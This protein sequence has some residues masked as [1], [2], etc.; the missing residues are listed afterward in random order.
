MRILLVEDD[1]DLAEVVALGLRNEAYAVDVAGTCADAEELLRT[2]EYDVACLDL[3]PARRR[4]A[5]PR[6]AA[7]RTTRTCA[8]RG[9][10]SC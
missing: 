6:P 9:G 4:R 8:G 2:T 7:R 1:A 3:G 10:R 5:R